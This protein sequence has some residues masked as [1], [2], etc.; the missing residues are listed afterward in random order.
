MKIGL[1]VVRLHLSKPKQRVMYTKWQFRLTALIT[2]LFFGLLM[3]VYYF[4]LGLVVND[5]YSILYAGIYL[6]PVAA[7]SYA[8]MILRN[9]YNNGYLSFRQSFKSSFLTGITVS[10]IFSAGLFFGIKYLNQP[11]FSLRSSMLESDVM[12]NSSSL[13]LDEISRQRELVKQFIAPFPVSVSYF[14]AN[15]ILIPFYAFF[16]AIFAMK[17]RKILKNPN[18]N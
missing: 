16:I 4:A 13:S 5:Y 18:L 12:L 11:V 2:G 10:L 8:P 3:L 9:R 1:E 17:R 6:I 15:L 7:Y 14:L